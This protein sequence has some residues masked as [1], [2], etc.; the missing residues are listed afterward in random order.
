MNGLCATCGKPL[1]DSHPTDGVVLTVKADDG[2]HHGGCWGKPKRDRIAELEAGL[3]RAIHL[4][5]V[6]RPISM[7]PVE[8]QD[9]IH[10]EEWASLTL[11]LVRDALSAPTAG[12]L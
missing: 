4:I 7:W 12:P 2:F 10:T 6:M 1:S 8:D 9:A 3:R 11:Q 5:E